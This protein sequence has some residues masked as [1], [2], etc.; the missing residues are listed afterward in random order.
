M[1]FIDHARSDNSSVV[2][3]VYT[4]SPHYSGQFNATCPPSTHHPF[5]PTV[6]VLSWILVGVGA[7]LCLSALLSGPQALIGIVFI[8]QAFCLR[9]GYI[10]AL[11]QARRGMPDFL[12]IFLTTLVVLKGFNIVSLI[13]GPT[14]YDSLY[15]YTTIENRIAAELILGLGLVCFTL[16]WHSLRIAGGSTFY[17]TVPE[18]LAIR[19][20]PFVLVGWLGLAHLPNSF[21]QQIGFMFHEIY[22]ALLFVIFAG[23]S[24]YGSEGSRS[25]VVIVLIVPALLSGLTSGTKELVLT[26][27]APVL[28]V[29]VLR[30]NLRR[31]GVTI[32]AGL[33]VIIVVVPIT[34]LYR[35]ANWSAKEN[36]GLTELFSRLVDAYQQMGASNIVS[37]GMVEFANRT[38]SSISGAIVVGATDRLGHT[39]LETVK[40]VFIVFVPRFL[41][42][43]KPPVAPGAWFTWH[44][45]YAATPVEAT[46]STATML[47]TELYMMS[48]W[49]TIPF[50][51]AALGLYYALIWRF[52]R[53]MSLRNPIM[54]IA[55]VSFMFNAVKFE[56][57]SLIYAITGPVVSMIYMFV[58]ASAYRMFYKPLAQRWRAR[59][60]SS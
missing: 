11:R 42:P 26:A 28:L 48:G 55:L 27:V 60:P 58:L 6:S 57:M 40:D 36:V 49:L 56:D 9:Y 54:G 14:E 20:V 25:W 24:R 4:A 29:Y 5:E 12:A 22:L 1:A 35:Q 18:G 44:L 30:P 46:T 17:S 53:T 15:Y 45:G 16:G 7:L 19:L 33:M 51:M 50:G 38:S 52:I 2:D 59:Y 31:I 32:L 13:V 21:A 23:K 10:R 39:G 43:E 3:L 34:Q 8:E 41:W 37:E 47:A